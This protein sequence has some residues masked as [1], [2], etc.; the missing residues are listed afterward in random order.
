MTTLRK[1]HNTGEK[2]GNH[3]GEMKKIVDH[4]GETT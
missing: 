3:L 2:I 4:L 1:I